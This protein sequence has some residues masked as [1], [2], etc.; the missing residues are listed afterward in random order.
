MV[1]WDKINLE[2]VLVQLKTKAITLKNQMRMNF[3]W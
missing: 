2:L 3:I 1:D